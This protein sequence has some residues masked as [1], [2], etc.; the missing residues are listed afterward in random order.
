MSEFVR[1]EGAA[2]RPFDLGELE[3]DLRAM[4]RSTSGTTGSP[5]SEERRRGTVYRAAM[6]N[7]VVPLDPE[8]HARMAPILVEITRR[9]PSRLLLV[10][11]GP[12]GSRELH[13]EVAALCHLRP[14]GGY[15]CS[16]QIILRGDAGAGPLVPS[17]V[18]ALLV[19]N[20]PT[21]LLDLHG[22]EPRPWIQDLADRADLVLYD[23]SESPSLDDAGSVWRAIDADTDNCVRD[24]AWSRLTP[25]REILAEG[26]DST[27]LAPACRN[28]REVTLEHGT[29][30][31]DGVPSC[32]LLLG[33]W[34]ASRLGW[35]VRSTEPDGATFDAPQ[36]SVRLRFAR[37]PEGTAGS[38]HRVQLRSGAPHSLDLR[39]THRPAH[40]EATVEVSAPKR[41]EVEIPFRYRDLAEC[42]MTEI[43]RHEPNPQL[44]SAVKCALL[45]LPT[46]GD[47]AA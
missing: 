44:T 8:R 39:V 37:D 47:R 34:L 5:G 45:L 31:T 27:H 33:G 21:V 13:A 32:L 18:G 17:A 9:H 29:P 26:F 35:R 2:S 1:V 15:I 16:E 25:W 30:E 43:H 38:L 42:L 22:G 24:L 10:E 12:G 23:T 7:L 6:S 4:W 14:A 41:Q 11:I 46:V 20:L 3:K 28:L 40:R 36:G 19:G